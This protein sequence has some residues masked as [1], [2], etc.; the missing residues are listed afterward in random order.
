[1]FKIEALVW[2]SFWKDF[3]F[4]PFNWWVGSNPRCQSKNIEMKKI[5]RIKLVH[6]LYGTCFQLIECEELRIKYLTPLLVV[7]MPHTCWF[8]WW[9]DCIEAFKWCLHSQYGVT[10][11]RVVLKEV[12]FEGL[13]CVWR[14][15]KASILN[16]GTKGQVPCADVGPFFKRVRNGWHHPKNGWC[17]S[18]T[19]GTLLYGV[20]V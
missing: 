8:L 4:Q 16:I 2:V 9:A 10:F 17:H 12:Y 13:N 19:E 14:S 7:T 5:A 15:L 11:W 6:E 18:F 1:M 20:L 3:K